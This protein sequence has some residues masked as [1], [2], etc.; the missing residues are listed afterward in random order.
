RLVLAVRDVAA[1]GLLER[2]RRLYRA[3]LSRQPAAA[4][5]GPRL[6]GDQLPR[7]QDPVRVERRLDP[8][9]DPDLGRAELERDEVAQDEADPVLARDR[10]AERDDAL[11]H[12]AARAVAAVEPR[13]L[14][15]LSAQEV[16]V[17]VAVA[18]VAVADRGH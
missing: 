17:E 5:R 9:Q 18:G 10:P 2:A 6:V 11:D 12:G 7:V 13:R 1:R 16:H 8:A 14:V 15:E 4:Q 3:W